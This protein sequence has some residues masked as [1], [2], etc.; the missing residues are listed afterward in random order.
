MTTKERY[1]LQL[2]NIVKSLSEQYY[3]SHDEYY[4]I[5]NSLLHEIENG[6]YSD[7]YVAGFMNALHSVSEFFDDKA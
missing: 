7:D 2:T 5:V 4:A 3:M 1:L 6:D